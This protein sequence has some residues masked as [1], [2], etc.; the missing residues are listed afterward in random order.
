MS[1]DTGLIAAVGGVWA[2]LAILYAT[3]PMLDMPGS[4]TIWGGGAV[5]FLALAGVLALAERRSA[6][7]G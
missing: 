7:R 5:L 6:R 1:E 2:L 4:V 3:V